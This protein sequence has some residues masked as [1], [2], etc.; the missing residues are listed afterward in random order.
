MYASQKSRPIMASVSVG[1]AEGCVGGGFF[2]RWGV[3]F[4]WK[5]LGPLVNF[6]GTPSEFFWRSRRGTHLGV[7]VAHG[8][9]PPDGRPHMGARSRPG[10]NAPLRGTP[11][12]VAGPPQRAD[13]GRG[14]QPTVRKTALSCASC[15][16]ATSPRLQG[17]RVLPSIASHTVS[18]FTCLCKFDPELL[19]QRCSKSLLSVGHIRVRIIRL[20][21]YR[22]FARE[23]TARN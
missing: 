10:G 6:R 9:A 3:V 4:L 11:V 22:T 5:R 23:A 8:C 1:C 14:R 2:C 21:Q 7:L 13:P 19:R 16:L 15:C 20:R 18:I 17:C 12:A